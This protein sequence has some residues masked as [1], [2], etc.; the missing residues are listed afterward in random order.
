MEKVTA[1]RMAVA[2]GRETAE[3]SAEL[4]RLLLKGV[5]LSRYRE[6]VVVPD[7]PLYFL[8][9][10]I[11]PSEGGVPLRS[12]GLSVLPSAKLFTELQKRVASEGKEMTVFADPIYSDPTS[13]AANRALVPLGDLS[14]LPGT[15]V[16]ADILE[17]LGEAKGYTVNRHTRGGASRNELFRA[18]DTGQLR[19]SRYLHF[20]THGHLAPQD[21][22]LSGLVL[23]VV[24][25]K[26]EEVN[27]FLRLVDIYRLDLDAELVV[28][29][30]CQTGLGTV[31]EGEGL[32][33]LY[34]GFMMAG[35]RGVLNTLWSIDDDGT[36]AFMRYF[37]DSL[38]S[39]KEPKEALSEAQQAMVS[40]ERWSAPVYWAGF[41][42]V[43]R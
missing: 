41:Q 5:D 31:R 23:S 16:E 25:E 2:G 19:E 7:G 38:L 18:S 15:A 35:S 26:G 28:L 24:D 29:S 36:A 3:L 6:V 4:G 8:P 10:S 22:R 9:F 43:S 17:E 11:L 33:G 32:Q 34:Q 37:Y 12:L 14:P 21:A 13:S 40:S 1:L 27:A 39:G 30:A 42:L 20:A